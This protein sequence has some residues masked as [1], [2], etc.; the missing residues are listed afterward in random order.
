[1]PT[2]RA[3]RMEAMVAAIAEANGSS[4]DEAR[5]IAVNLVEANLKGHDSHGLGLMPTYVNARQ[6]GKLRPNRHI[7]VVKDDGAILLLDGNAGYGQV[8]GAEAMRLGIER[9]QSHGLCL[10]SLRNSHHLG[11]IGAWGEM[12]AD[13]GLISI[14]W[15]NG[16][17]KMPLVAPYGGS[18]ARYTTNPYCTAIPETPDHPRII[19]D[20]ATTKV[21]QGKVR[22][23]YNKGVEVPP[24]CLID[25]TGVM[26]T[27]P[28]VMF[29][30]PTGALM[31]VGQHKGYGLALICEILAGG[32]S[33]GGTFLPERSDGW[34]IINNMLTIIVDPARL[35]DTGALYAEI[36]DFIRHVKASPPAPGVDAVMVPGDPERKS[37]AER[38]A[39]GLPIDDQTWQ[40]MVQCAVQ[41]G[42]DEKI[43]R[44]FGEEAA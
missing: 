24:D 43:A 7:S 34:S 4:E 1:M 19:F 22:V 29:E 10:M 38:G 13:A 35:G 42:I 8:I 26:T 27:N 6:Y 21:A 15:V 31:S 36:D 3:E 40:E 37:S 32:L 33:G 16:I 14:H 18:D 5:L 41:S 20:M 44:A 2:I 12:A 30:E 28:A 9:A 39:N 17:T 25:S 11:R 23:A